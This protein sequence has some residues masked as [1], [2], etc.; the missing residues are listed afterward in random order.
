[1]TLFG[2]TVANQRWCNRAGFLEVRAYSMTGERA[3]LNAWLG[4]A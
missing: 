1:M 2:R 3:C 4:G